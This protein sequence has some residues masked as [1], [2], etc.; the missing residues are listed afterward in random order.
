MERLLEKGEWTLF[1]SYDT[2]E[3]TELYGEDFKNKY[4]EY[5]NEFKRNPSKFNKETK[6]I[7]AVELMR[8]IAHRYIEDGNPF[9]FFHD[10]AN[11]ENPYKELGIVR[12]SNLCFT[13]DT[14]VK[15]A[16]GDKT[17]EELYQIYGSKTDSVKDG[18]K[19]IVHGSILNTTTGKNGII[20]KEWNNVT[21]PAI[22]FKT[23]KCKVVKVTL[24][25]GGEFKC[26][27]NHL[28]AKSNGGYV[29]A[30]NSVN[31][32]VKSFDGNHDI[33]V[34]K[35][36]ELKEEYDV[37]DL[38][39]PATSN[40]YISV[41]R[42]GILV[43]NC[44]I[45]DTKI[46]TKEYGN[47]P[48]KELV[49]NG[50]K[51][52][53]C[54]NG[55]EWSMTKLAKTNDNAHILKVELD[56]GVTVECTD[57]HDWYVLQDEYYSINRKYN[58]IIK[59]KT[60]ELKPKD[61]LIRFN[62]PEEI[63]NGSE[64]LD[65]AYDNGLF[66]AEGCCYYEKT[67]FIYLYSNKMDL[68]SRLNN[69]HRITDVRYSG[70]TPFIRV[71]YK[72][73]QLKNKFFVPMGKYR[74]K[75]K[76]DW[77]AGYLDGDGTLLD[78]NGVQ[79]IQAVSINKSFLLDILMLLQEIGIYSNVKKCSLAGLRLLP[80]NDGTG[81]Y[82]EYNCK[83]SYRIN[84]PGRE[85][86]KLLD[87]G[88]TFNRLKPYKFN[89]KVSE[90]LIKTFSKRIRVKNIIDENKYT[91]TYCGTEPKKHMLM[92]NGVL[93]GQ[94]TEIIMPTD[95]DKTAVC[96][97]GSINLARCN[98]TEELIRV[99][100]LALR[101]MDNCIDLT[102][103]PSKESERW[104]KKLRSTGLGTLGL[105]EYL[106]NEQIEYGSDKHKSELHRIYGTISDTIKE[107]SRNLAKEKGECIVKGIRNAYRMAI[108]PN[109]SSAMFAGTT[110]SHELVYNLL[111][112]ETSKV[113]TYPITAPHISLDNIN[114]YKTPY[115]V[116]PLLQIEMTS[117]IQKYIDQGISHNVYIDP[118]QYE[119]GVPLSK[120]RD[121][122]VH[123]WRNGMKTLYYC[124]SKAKKNGEI[125]EDKIVCSGCEN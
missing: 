71:Y 106:A 8:A 57:Q 114:Y 58:K 91:A 118:N 42:L 61:A 37:Y 123:A 28:L 99:T 25:N 9:I 21:T 30:I 97:L 124:R 13:G 38:N 105:A 44:V 49:D 18:E 117:I 104:Q 116:D 110:N 101:S 22:V 52:T 119:N 89:Y 19:F 67:P 107:E 81:G 39:V 115:Q 10:T 4:I 17:I 15:T 80:A 5:E 113:G 23:G 7:P 62:L 112:M 16:A 1:S 111:W 78:A 72:P 84:I 20:R 31:N 102:V 73:N 48:I 32:N 65:N 85:I 63:M 96:N 55:D 79:A 51:E 36:E 24:N 6:T 77:L 12:S 83:D 103:Y 56:N 86:N 109:S 45:G 68:A 120:I 88:I 14:I 50:V 100:K 27:P 59:K 29:E 94:C 35:V 33:F 40:F 92:F 64:V 54:W 70:K 2:P 53:E 98:T 66:S 82:K 74:L 125:K 75:D 41:N 47:I 121:I 93:T 69:Y 11:R 95:I 122:I 3:L 60:T 43:H 34:I 108:A 26:T 90:G 87:M 46:L 76:L